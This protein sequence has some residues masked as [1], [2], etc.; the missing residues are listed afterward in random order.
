[1]PRLQPR[2]ISP[3]N[4]L[5]FQSDAYS[6]LSD[7]TCINWSCMN[8]TWNSLEVIFKQFDTLLYQVLLWAFQNNYKGL[9]GTQL[10]LSQK[11]TKLKELLL[12]FTYNGRH[13]GFKV[14]CQIKCRGPLRGLAPAL[15]H[16]RHQLLAKISPLPRQMGS[17]SKKASEFCQ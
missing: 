6:I 1:M 7:N 4:A 11:K 17:Q 2:L 12:Y 3:T 8:Q 5:G 15:T 16:F 10:H 14:R 13:C 9:K